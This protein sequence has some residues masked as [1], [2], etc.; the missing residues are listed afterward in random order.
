MN[1]MQ[2]PTSD[3]IPLGFGMALAQNEQALQNFAHM[4][5][6]ERQRVLFDARHVRTKNEMKSLITRIGGIQ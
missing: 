4:D 1:E 6:R 2:K 5:E 3:E